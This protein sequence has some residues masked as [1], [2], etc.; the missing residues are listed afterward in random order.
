MTTQ[1]C[2]TC[3][4]KKDRCYCAPNS[5]CNGYEEE[6]LTEKEFIDEYCHNCGSQSGG[7]YEAL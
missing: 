2:K 4:H 1:I 5:I 3:K 6:L 7:N